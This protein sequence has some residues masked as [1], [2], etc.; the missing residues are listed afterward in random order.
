MRSRA[1][2]PFAA[3]AALLHAACTGVVF[4][5]GPE[6]GA[7]SETTEPG[8]RAGPEDTGSGPS[9]PGPAPALPSAA[10]CESR[11]LGRSYRSFDGQAREAQRAGTAAGIDRALPTRNAARGG[12]HELDR[13][14]TEALDIQ[15]WTELTAE[16]RARST[17]ST[18]GVPKDRWFSRVNLGPMTAVKLASLA[19]MACDGALRRATGRAY[20][21]RP[22]FQSVPTPEA[23]EPICAQ[24]MEHA[25]RRVPEPEELEACVN[26]AIE[27]T[28][29][30]P[31]PVRRWAYVC[32]SVFASVEYIVR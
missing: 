27:G 22:E 29:P 2:L 7:P 28:S 18:F 1:H 14:F 10:L 15:A 9:G 13:R 11:S 6:R 5:P 17:Q 16:L 31:D 30:E 8:E 21:A 4:D 24:L 26:L 19:F 23:A 32:S 12:R 25:W 20:F 3:A